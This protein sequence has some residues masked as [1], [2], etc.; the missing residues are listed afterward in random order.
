MKEKLRSWS[1]VFELIRRWN[2]WEVTASIWPL[3]VP[4]GVMNSAVPG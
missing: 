2:S 3:I 4:Y 1:R